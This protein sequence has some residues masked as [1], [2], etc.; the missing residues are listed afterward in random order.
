M[1]INNNTIKASEIRLPA[2]EL[3]PELAVLRD[4]KFS[5]KRDANDKL[6]KDIEFVK[7]E[8]IDDT[9]FN[10]FTIKVKDDKPIIELKEFEKSENPVYIQ[11][12][13]DETVI[14]PYALEY[15]NLKLSITSPY[16]KLAQN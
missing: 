13:L 3:L 4:I 8:L 1:R 12:P 5:Y 15:G 14:K 11:I 16:V 7:Y 9:N 10:I 2:K 6:T